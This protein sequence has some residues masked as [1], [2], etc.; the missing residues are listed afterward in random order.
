MS[1]TTLIDVAT[2][3][4][5]LDD[6]NW[7]FV[8]CRFDMA[9]HD[10]GRQAYLEAHIP[11]AMYVHLEEDMSSDPVTDSG[12]HP[13]PSAEALAM[14]FARLGI[15]A[16]TQVVLYDAHNG[17]FASRLWWMLNYMGHTAVSVLDGGWQA[18]VAANGATKAGEEVNPIAQFTGSP[19]REMLVL[20]DDVASQ[21]LL[22]DSRGAARYRGDEEPLDTVAGHIPGAVNYFFQQNWENGRYISAAA[23]KQN[24]QALLGDVPVEQATFYCGSGVSA[25]INLLALRHAGLGNGRLYVGSWSEWSSNPTRP[26][27]TTP[28]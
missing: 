21:P 7:V 6:D 16:G 2:L 17:V 22:I 12:R 10:A 26:Q 15:G 27:E 8:D 14:L 19:N 13:L 1:F 5:H 11:R 24:L 9:N 18:W 28:Q 23:M 3:Q 25:C 4:E 20:V